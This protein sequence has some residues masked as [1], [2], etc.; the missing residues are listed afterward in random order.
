MGSNRLC[1]L[2]E[3]AQTASGVRSRLHTL[4]SPL[5]L[6]VALHPP[7]VLEHSCQQ[8]SSVYFHFSFRLFFLCI[9][10][11]SLAKTTGTSALSQCLKCSLNDSKYYEHSVRMQIDVDVICT[12]YAHSLWRMRNWEWIRSLMPFA[13]RTVLITSESNSMP[14]EFL[15]A[16]KYLCIL[17]VRIQK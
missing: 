3:R 11:T 12:V 6:N 15:H 8:P 4:G 16:L 10:G 9:S 13:V 14:M 17:L 2:L 7:V 5:K 1:F